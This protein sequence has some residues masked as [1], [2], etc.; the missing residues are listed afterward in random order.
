MFMTLFPFAF[1]SELGITDIILDIVHHLPTFECRTSDPHLEQFVFRV[2]SIRS[3]DPAVDRFDSVMEVIETEKH[4][5]FIFTVFLDEKTDLIWKILKLLEIE[6]L[7]FS[8]CDWIIERVEFGVKGS[9]AEA[10]LP[11]TYY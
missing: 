9:N 4:Q 1:V 10:Y 6:L 11:T 5:V 8:R 7:H 2:V 3:D